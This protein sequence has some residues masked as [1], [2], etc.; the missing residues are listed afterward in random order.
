MP[1]AGSEDTPG[2]FN[3]IVACN[4]CLVPGGS[5]D[6]PAFLQ[7][8]IDT[9]RTLALVAN[10]SAT[11]SGTPDSFRVNTSTWLASPS[12][13][14][15]RT[16]DGELLLAMYG[17]A[18][19]SGQACGSRGCYSTVFFKS[20]NNGLEWQYTSRIDQTSA[21]P[22]PSEGPCEPSIVVLDDGTVLSVFRL[23][24]GVQLWGARS[25]DNGA[26][27]DPPA[28]LVACPGVEKNPYGVWPQLLKSNGQI[29]L[30]SGRPGIGLWTADASGKC[31]GSYTDVI[32]VHNA[33]LPDDPFTTGTE[34]TSYT[35]VAELSSGQVSAI[36]GSKIAP[37][38][39]WGPL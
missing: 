2:Q 7:T 25:H 37:R 38:V 15:V 4:D 19:D 21:M 32:A 39:G 24:G 18:A 6:Q 33:T 34:T 22:F 1:N 28:G 29:V 30:V 10:K 13:T 11:F 23:D 16:A 35:G 8:W 9:G 17:H 20:K 3:T 31:W 36:L 5:V 26:T 14:I 27:W 12:Q